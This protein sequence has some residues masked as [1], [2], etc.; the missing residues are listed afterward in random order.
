MRDITKQIGAGVGDMF[1]KVQN[2]GGRAA[3]QNDARTFFIMRTSQLA[4]WNEEMRQSYL[5]DLRARRRLRTQ[6][7]CGKIRLHDGA[8]LPGGI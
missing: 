8:H 4:A 5:D 6:S 2:R 7:T 3:C 1:G